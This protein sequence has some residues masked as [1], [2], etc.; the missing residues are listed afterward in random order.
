MSNLGD[1]LVLVNVTWDGPNDPENPKN[2]PASRKW[3][4][5]I[6]MSLFNLLSSMSSATVAPALEAIADDLK[7]RSQTLLIMSLSVYLLGS[8]IVP[9][10][11]SGMN[12]D[13][14]PPQDRWKAMAVFTLA[15]L[16]GTAIGPITGGFLVQYESWPWCFYVVSI[17]AAVVQLAAFLLLRETYGP[18]LLRRKCA[19]MRKTTGNPDL[20]T[21]YD[22]MS[23]TALLH[24]NL[25]R[26][27]RLLATQP[28]IQ[29]LSLYLAYLNGILYLMV[30]TF[31]DV[32]TTIYHESESIGS[33]NYLSLT[34]GMTIA[35]QL[36]TR[37]AGRVYQ[38]LCANN[39][40]V[41]RPEFRLPILCAGACIVPIGLFWY[42]W[43]ARQ[44]IHWIMPNIGAAI[45]A[46]STVV[47]LICV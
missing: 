27:F 47:Q 10:I 13:L 4:V 6:P 17:A 16:I 18:V 42:G 30:A 31:P 33:L 24:K 38:R 28:I 39:G 19:R 9:L 12:S 46:G 36:G 25:I 5:F 34:V 29:V 11:G 37:I 41:A 26:P 7:I 22:G 3:M 43:S 20:Y 32:W 21:E 44:S 1:A 14:F 23:S 2:W 15:P 35:M 45:Y 40:G 8:A